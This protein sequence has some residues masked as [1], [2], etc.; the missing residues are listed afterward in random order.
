MK[1]SVKFFT[2]SEI[3]NTSLLHTKKNQLKHMNIFDYL[4]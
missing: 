3:I 4:R 1:L 2:L